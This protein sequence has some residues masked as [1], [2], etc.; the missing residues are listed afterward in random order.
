VAASIAYWTTHDEDPQTDAQLALILGR[1]SSIER[2]VR[3][4][5]YSEPDWPVLARKAAEYEASKTP[6]VHVLQVDSDP[7]NLDE[8]EDGLKKRHTVD[9][10]QMPQAAKPGDI[11]VWYATL[12]TGAYV[13]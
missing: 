12:P 10:W 3:T 7:A 5:V 13:A 9:D 1:L 8:L 11:A 6:I 2:M 4:Q